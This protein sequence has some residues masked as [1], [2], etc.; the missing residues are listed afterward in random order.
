MGRRKGQKRKDARRHACGKL[1]QPKRIEREHQIKAIGEDARIRVHGL[2]VAQAAR[3]EAG[4]AIGR[5]F[6]LGAITRAQAEAAGLYEEVRREYDRAILARAMRSGGNFDG[7][8]GFDGSDGDDP[9]YVAA[10]AAMR[11][12]FTASRHALLTADPLAMLAADTWIIEGIEA[13]GMIGEL[14]LGLNAL[15]RLYRVEQW[16]GVAA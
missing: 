6:M 13:W 2:S 7:V 11:A 5:A 8:R 16:I 1:V 9:G 12:R 3:P 4:Y 14:R 15:A 10:V